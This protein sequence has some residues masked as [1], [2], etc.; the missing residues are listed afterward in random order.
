MQRHAQ[1]Y[2]R[3]FLL[4]MFGYTVF[5]LLSVWLLKQMPDTPWRY[6]IAIVPMLPL[7]FALRAYLRYLDRMDEL[8]QRIQLQAVSF[9]AGATG[10]LTLTYGFLEG[11]GLPS[12]SYVW[13]FPLLIAL[14]RLAT[15]VLT[16]RYQ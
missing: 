11:V 14:W 15:A 1:E 12:L 9:A 16:R 2:T 5:V 13:I 7:F 10:M 4:A 8:Q 3:N 6:L